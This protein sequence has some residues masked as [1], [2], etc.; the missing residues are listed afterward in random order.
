ME[1]AEKLYNL[2]L[3]KAATKIEKFSD[4]IDLLDKKLDNAIGSKSKNKLVDKQTKEEK[5]TLEAYKTASKEAAKNY[6]TAKK[7]LG[8]SSTL[9]NSGVNAKEKKTIK[10]A[11]KAGKEVNLSYF[12]EGSKGYNAAVKYNEALKARTKA[13]Y[14]LA[15]AQEEY[16]SWLV[17][18]SKIKF[19]NIADDYEKKV[20]MLDHQVK[21]IDNRISEIETAGKKVNRSYYDTQK[22]INAQK[23]AEYRQEK[24][25]LEES[26]KNIKQ[27]TDE[28]YEAF[29]AIRQVSSAISDCVKETYNLN[30]AI[31]QLRFDLF[32]DIAE[33]I[34]CIITEQEFLQGLF[35]HEKAADSETGNLT[36][37]GLAKLG[38]LSASYYASKN[39]ADND[40]ELLKELQ[41]VMEKGKQADG[42]YK[43]GDWE[44][45]SLDDLQAK[46][47]ETYTAWQNDIK[48]TYSLETSLVD[49][50]KE[51]Y[52]AELDLIKELIERKKEALQAEKDLHDYQKTITEKTDNIATIQKQIAAYSGDTSQEGLA[53]LQKLQKEL[54]DKQEDLR[55]TEYDRY[56]SD[57]QDMLD[58]LYEEYEEQITK[59][60]EDFMG[61][62]Q[63]G[64]ATANNNLSGINDY[65][66]K[67][68]DSNGYIEQTKGLFNVA[69]GDIKANTNSIVSAIE[70]YV[71]KNSGTKSDEQGNV[72]ANSAKPG[73]A[74]TNEKKPA[75]VNAN[76]NNGS[77]AVKSSS[78]T[79]SKS[80]ENTKGKQEENVLIDNSKN[81]LVGSKKSSISDM[82]RTASSVKKD[83]ITEGIFNNLKKLIIPGF[84]KGGMV[85]VDDIEKQV[86]ENGD[87]GLVSVKNGEC[88]VPANLT[89]EIQKL[90]EYVPA[91]S[92]LAHG[93]VELPKVP[94]IEPVRNGGNRDIN[95]DFGGIT[96]N[97]VNDPKEFANQLVRS[98]QTVPKA[99]KVIQSVSTDM[100]ASGGKLGVQSIR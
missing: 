80:K 54:A 30:N 25:D 94:V 34:D 44:F 5:K 20:Q 16:T 12:T 51:K 32:D 67:V 64:L 50:M 74:A 3:D 56:I 27:G 10:A 68:A 45:N 100:L 71:E 81:V 78:T 9:K 85:S 1:T 18:A 61:L 60:L 73:S 76:T 35:A 63:E 92:N 38:S 66:S 42:K 58:K 29:D 86:H 83:S 93:L 24:A 98:V 82:E 36:E 65:L 69:T 22:A 13:T 89:P 49:V 19:D 75:T 7:T 57:Q 43:L 79:V 17:E 97:G 14:D 87:D 72:V 70:K 59:K 11:V 90:T 39:K 4:A 46:I 62:V 77:T 99:R 53:K 41:A 28:W 21:A 23:L 40:E 26:L 6:K 37:A 33:S 84:K 88:I 31:N 91:M 47:E 96:M 8:K 55:E 52:Q 95:I 15:T 48:E 2:P